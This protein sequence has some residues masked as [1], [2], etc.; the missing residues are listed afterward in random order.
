M[1]A[2]ILTSKI[3]CWLRHR[4]KGFWLLSPDAPTRPAKIV[5][6]KYGHLDLCNLG[7][8]DLW[9]REASAQIKFSISENLN[10]DAFFDEF[11]FLCHNFNV[12]NLMTA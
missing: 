10:K 4:P 12:Y 11:I 6:E 9:V 7:T 8:L 3:A 5:R 1:R 2:N